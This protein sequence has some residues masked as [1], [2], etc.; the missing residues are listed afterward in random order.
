MRVPGG[1]VLAPASKHDRRL[2]QAVGDLAVGQLVARLRVE[3]LAVIATKASH[4]L[5]NEA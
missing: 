5:T 3:A 2:G 4:S 1:V